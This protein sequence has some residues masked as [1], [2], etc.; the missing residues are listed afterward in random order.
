M[1]DSPTEPDVVRAALGDLEGEAFLQRLALVRP[2]LDEALAE[3]YGDRVDPAAFADLLVAD[4]LAAT[5]ARDPALAALDRRREID[6]GWFLAEDMIGYVC[7]A[8]R[9]AGGL[10]GV[11][12]HLDH[13]AELGVRYLHL[14]PLL[15]PR[16]GENDGGYAVADY[17]AVDRRLG[18]MAD[19]EA[20]A[21]EAHRRGIALC[22]DLVLNHTARDHQW[23]R[24]AVAGDPTYRSF[25]R[26]F[27]DRTEPDAYER[28]LPEVFPDLA[29]GSF[30]KVEETGEWVWTTFHDYQWDLDWSNPQVFR[31]MLGV[32]LS[33]TGRG[34]D[35]LRLDAVPFLWKRLGTDCQNQP[36]AHRILQALKALVRLARPGVVLKAEAIV[37]PDQ[38]VPYLGAHEVFRPECDL[39]YDNQLMVML[40]SALAT[41]DV[42][43]LV[44]A[45][46]RR[47]PAPAGTG[48]V[49]YV[50]CHDDIG[51]AVADEDA[52][53]VGIDPGAHRRFLASFFAGD[54]P[55]SFAR[56]LVFQ[57]DPVTG[58]GR[59]SG[60]CASLAG[61]EHALDLG[62]P[63]EVDAALRRIETLYAVVYSFGGIPLVYMGDE[64][65]LRNDR[66]W[67]GEPGHEADNRW[68]HRPRMD[69]AAADRRHDPTTLE[70][71]CF[72]AL[73]RLGEVRRSAVALRSD[74][75]TTVVP[76]DDPGVL[77]YVRRH[78]RAQPMLGLARFSD[79]PGVVDLAPVRA[80]T[81]VDRWRHVH[82][83]AGEQAPADGR[84]SL[85]AWG[86]VWLTAD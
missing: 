9:F 63:A 61:L 86:F 28:T 14:M 21:G 64:V 73:R 52:W 18:T 12:T 67:A 49:T 7:Y 24:R 2:D 22:V 11:T 65:A 20:L 35:V 32:M 82:S 55:G 36:E 25:Y 70:G 17:S 75:S 8:D 47:Q 59:T 57:P 56:G 68:L 29:P 77:A 1:N 13:L 23:A 81:G 83:T 69:W 79:D 39:A 6:P 41:R 72:A 85:P 27:P 30:S 15:Q 19:L 26:F 45:L 78:P 62:I 48:W 33:L 71:R 38:L 58:D 16:D 42:R 43:L 3:V 76:L 44:H 5:A 46:S 80:V 53:A 60:M 40:W 51:W 54:H 34:V 4:A 84:I 74:A 66:R 37:G 50:R 10:A 31:A